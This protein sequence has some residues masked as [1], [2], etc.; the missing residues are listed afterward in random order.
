[1]LPVP[2]DGDSDDPDRD[3]TEVDLF[4][5]LLSPIEA[6]RESDNQREQ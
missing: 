3:P 1:M 5:G 6:E 4:F 2:D